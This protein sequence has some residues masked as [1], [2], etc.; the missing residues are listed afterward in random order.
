M[1]NLYIDSTTIV[2]KKFTV[3]N[4]V[5]NAEYTCVGYAANDTFLIV[6]QYTDTV[7]NRFRLKTFKFQDVT[8]KP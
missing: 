5:S 7:N 6:G 8:F 2:G 1:T 3:A 4:D